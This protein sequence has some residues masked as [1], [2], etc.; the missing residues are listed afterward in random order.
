MH[1]LILSMVSISDRPIDASTSIDGKW[2]EHYPG[3][4]EEVP[5]DMPIPKGKGITLI[6]YIDADHAHDHITRRSAMP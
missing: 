3:A 5:R 1:F 2:S 4:K 6:T